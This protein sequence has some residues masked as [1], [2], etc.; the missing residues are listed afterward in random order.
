ME[1]CGTSH[2]GHPPLRS[3]ASAPRDGE[4]VSGPGC[5]VCVTP[6]S[7]IDEA[8]ALARQGVVVTSFGDMLR[9]PGSFSSLENERAAGA[10]VRAVYSPL[11]ALQNRRRQRLGKR[12][13]WP[14]ASLL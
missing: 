7:Y 9:V 11:D 14:W 13:S 1:V 10:D 5:P 6:D 12:S 2:R 8:A 3:A 4:L